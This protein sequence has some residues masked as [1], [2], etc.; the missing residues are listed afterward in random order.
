MGVRIYWLILISI[1]MLNEVQVSVFGVASTSE[2]DF[3]RGAISLRTVMR[4]SRPIKAPPPPKRN[5]P[6]HFKRT[7][8][9]PPPPPPPSHYYKLPP[10]LPI[11]SPPFHPP[12]DLVPPPPSY[13][14][15]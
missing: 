10:A 2:A 15:V 4:R 3:P 13:Y 6:V 1:F 8:P 7:P 9:L 5:V 11:Y 12:S 14:R